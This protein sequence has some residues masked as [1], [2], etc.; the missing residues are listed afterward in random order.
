[1]VKM[2]EKIKTTCDNCGKVIYQYS[3]FMKKFKHHFC[4]KTCYGKWQSRNAIK[5]NHSAWKGGKVEQICEQ[6]NRRFLV[7]PS[8]IRQGIKFCSKECYYK[9]Q[10]IRRIKRI[11]KYCGKQFEVYLSEIK[12]GRGNFCS[13]K[14]Q[15]LWQSIH[16]KGRDM[17][18]LRV[19]LH[20]KPSKPE[21]IFSTNM[22]KE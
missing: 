20:Q 4:N 22:S 10:G 19:N 2:A 8:R 1:M 17:T 12:K 13:R 7:F 18:H 3:S 16:W 14:C 9:A 15:G 6:C 21:R 5:G 11:C